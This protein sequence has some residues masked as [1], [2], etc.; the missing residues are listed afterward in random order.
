LRSG[1]GGLVVGAE[2]REE[3][4]GDVFDA[5]GHGGVGV[6]YNDNDVELIF[7]GDAIHFNICGCTTHEV[8][9][10]LAVDC[11]EGVDIVGGAS[12]YFD[13]YDARAF[14]GDDIEF[15]MSATPV[16]VADSVTFGDEEV[17]GDFFAPRTENVVLSHNFF[18]NISN[19]SEKKR[20]KMRGII[21]IF[22]VKIL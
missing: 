19:F 14:H 2:G 9:D 21:V 18:T 12:F 7:V 5:W 6:A 22:A 17:D 4:V 20:T 10:T 16:C 8:V 11:F 3:G 13:E 15:E 1:E